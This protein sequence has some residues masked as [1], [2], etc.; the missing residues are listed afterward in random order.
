MTDHQIK[1]LKQI[2]SSSER[3]LVSSLPRILERYYPSSA[4][5]ATKDY[6]YASGD[7]PV[8]L[9][10]HLDTVFIH[11]PK[12]IYRDPKA[13]VLWS[14]TG[15][16][17]DDRAGV[18]SILHILE[19]GYRPSVIFTT[20][21]EKGGLG[22]GRLVKK[23]PNPCTPLNFLVELD[24]Q[25][26]M[27]AVYYDCGNQAFESFISTFGFTTEHGSFSDIAIIGPIWDIASVNLSI[28]YYEEH[29]RVERLYYQ[30]MF[31]TI[32]VVENLIESCGDQA[33]KYQALPYYYNFMANTDL[34]CDCCNYAY[35]ITSF[36]LVEDEEGDQWKLCP[37]C[38]QK[39]ADACPICGTLIFNPNHSI[40]DKKCFICSMEDA[41][42]DRPD[43]P[44]ASR[45]SN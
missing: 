31:D 28:G 42:G 18:Y 45:K 36:T 20:G 19:D 33:F 39:H 29:S 13:G 43:Y 7:L 8:G 38:I 16:G 41:Y 17:A 27:E 1:L 32:S 12:A 11:P 14:P 15:L 21:E 37:S 6:I 3:A 44:R 5:H 2:L 10:A 23:F 40:T 26:Y 4:I 9:I 34:L 30:L 35:P 24:R 22:A 25:G